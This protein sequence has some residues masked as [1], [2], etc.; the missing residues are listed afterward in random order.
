MKHLYYERAERLV[1]DYNNVDSDVSFDRSVEAL[2]ALSKEIMDGGEELDNF[3]D[4]ILEYVNEQSGYRDINP[5]PVPPGVI[6]REDFGNEYDD[7][8]PITNII[9]SVV[10]SLRE[11]ID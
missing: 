2:K 4:M 7:V 5:K 3:I 6:Q 10:R 1:D 8:D 11:D 9:D